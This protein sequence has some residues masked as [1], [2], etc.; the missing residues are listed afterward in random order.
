V[1][2][3]ERAET[4]FLEPRHQTAD[5][6]RAEDTEVHQH[7]HAERAEEPA[8]QELELFDR[9]AE[10]ERVRAELEVAMDRVRHEGGGGEDAED[11]H[12]QQ[13]LHDH[14]RRVA[15]DVA[16]GA[17]HRHRVA[18]RRAE[19]QQ[20]EDQQQDVEE[21]GLQVVSGFEGSDCAEH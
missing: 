13:E 10:E 21:R 15:V 5:G 1:P 18:R 7:G 16:D 12:H 9:R 20:K 17:A 4:L 6:H 11:A 2:R 3:H 14:E 8:G 19:R